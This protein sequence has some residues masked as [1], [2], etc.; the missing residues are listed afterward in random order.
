MW[1][2]LKGNL[3]RWLGHSPLAYVPVRVRGGLAKGAR[4][5][6][7]PYSMYWR[8]HSEADV[9]NAIRQVGDL[10]G[11]ACWDL[12]AHFGFFTV[13]LAFA[14][15]ADGEVA[16]FEP[17]PVSFARCQRH[18]RMNR[19]ANVRLFHAA[20]SAEPGDADLL[21]YGDAGLSTSHLAYPGESG[22]GATRF[23]VR[24]VRLD[25]LVAAGEIRPPR[26]VK[27]DVEGHGASALRGAGKTVERHRPAI[28][29]SFHTLDEFEETRRLVDPLGYRMFACRSDGPQPWSQPV[30]SDTRLLLP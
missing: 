11:A 17:D 7:L 1:K 10:R 19:L 2:R 18:I 8:G 28:V 23:R 13:G 22:V 6:L 20:V 21:L 3:S 5:T 26:L 16:G 25:D 29:M 14:V 4:W 30:T 12:G 27:V 24:T 15:G 9:E